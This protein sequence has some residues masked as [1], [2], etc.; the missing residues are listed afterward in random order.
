[1]EVNEGRDLKGLVEFLKKHNPGGMKEL[2][3]RGGSIN[4][5]ALKPLNKNHS[6]RVDQ[7]VQ[8]LSK[9]MS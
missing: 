2:A 1:M 6:S 7:M 3:D 8:K 5:K 9:L 4:G